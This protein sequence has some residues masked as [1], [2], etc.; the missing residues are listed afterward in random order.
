MAW[1]NRLPT[2][3]LLL[4]ISQ[5]RSHRDFVAFS[6]T[7]RAIHSLTKNELPLRQKHRRIRIKSP[8][9]SDKAF[10]ILLSILRR[11]QLG[12]YVRHIEYDRPP[13]SYHDYQIR[14]KDLKELSDED[15]ERL[16]TAV[17]N[18]GF[19]GE[20]AEKVINMI[21]QPY[22]PVWHWGLV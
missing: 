19:T 4:T 12:D 16:Q 9:D 3:V 20:Y 7:C 18:S 17:K 10:D 8:S 13:N 14:T 11:P 1:F 5:V 2:E 6:R 21:L 15:Y 22:D